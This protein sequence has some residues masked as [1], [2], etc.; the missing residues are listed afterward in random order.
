MIEFE[1]DEAKSRINK[2]KHGID[3]FAAQEMWHT[4]QRHIILFS[5]CKKTGEGRWLTI[6]RIKTKLWTAV[7]TRREGKIRII[8]MRRARIEEI[9]L[10]EKNNR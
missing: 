7:V 9:E 5:P 8:T 2:E 10:Y 3:F 6:G 4:P 1:F